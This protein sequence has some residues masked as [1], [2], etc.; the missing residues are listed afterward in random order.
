MQRLSAMKIQELIA[1]R[2]V[3]YV[4]YFNALLTEETELKVLYAPLEEILN[5]Y[6]PAVAKLKLSVQ[7]RVNLDPRSVCTEL[8]KLFQAVSAHR[9]HIDAPAKRTAL[10]GY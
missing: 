9:L 10:G 3:R 2:T 8:V 7:R 6:C 4:A 1:G 5:N